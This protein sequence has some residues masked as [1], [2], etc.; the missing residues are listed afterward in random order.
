MVIC[1]CLKQLQKSIGQRPS[2]G[3]KQRSE[4]LFQVG[5]GDRLADCS[6]NIVRDI[7]LHSLKLSVHLLQLRLTVSDDHLELLVSARE[8]SVHGIEGVNLAREIRFLL[9]YFLSVQIALP[10]VSPLELVDFSF[11]RTD[12]CYLL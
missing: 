5:L 11:L 2:R 4:L 9:G 1:K 12:G 8:V 10:L 3:L 7:P 6:V